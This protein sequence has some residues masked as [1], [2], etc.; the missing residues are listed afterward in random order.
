MIRVP[1]VPINTEHSV[2][3][4]AEQDSMF[5]HRAPHHT[6]SACQHP[7]TLK[8]GVSLMS[9]GNKDNPIQSW[10]QFSRATAEGWVTFLQKAFLKQWGWQLN[11]NYVSKECFFVFS[12]LRSMIILSAEVPE[13]IMYLSSEE[14][15]TGFQLH[16]VDIYSW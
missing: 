7:E 5:M 13:T 6:E 10:Y 11:S 2:Q 4:T 9:R 12:W 16:T 3:P 8:A 14:Q 1:V 15:K